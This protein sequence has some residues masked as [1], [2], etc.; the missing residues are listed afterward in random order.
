MRM[1][2]DTLGWPA[3][4]IFA[5]GAV[6]GLFGLTSSII[7]LHG[8]L[9]GPSGPARQECRHVETGEVF[10]F[11]LEG[12]TAYSNGI[13]FTDEAGWRRVITEQNNAEWKCREI[14]P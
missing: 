2:I 1:V 11:R 3:T 8:A 10:R 9:N 4:V 5:I 12:V 6:V 13:E 7:N 14:A